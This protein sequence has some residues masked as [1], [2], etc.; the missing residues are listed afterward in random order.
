MQ[1]LVHRLYAQPWLLLTLCA[2]FWGGNAV[3]GRMA[4]G[5]IAPF[6][7]VL[8][9]WV[10]VSIAM[11]ALYGNE[12]RRHW[13]I[14]RP[15]LAWIVI[16][17]TIG[18]TTFNALFYMA[19]LQTTAV[20][21]GILQGTMPVIVL[22]GA[23][24]VYRTKVTPVQGVGVL[25]TLTGVAMIASRG[26]PAGLMA[27][28]INPGDGIMLIACVSYAA[29]TVMLRNRP[30]IPGA[31]FF[32]LLAVVA[33]VT[34]VPLAVAEAQITSPDWPSQKGWLITLFVAIFP[35]CLSQLFFLRGVDLIGPGRAG[36]YF[37][38]VPVFAAFLAVL[39][40]GETFAWYHAVAL[41]LVLGGIALAQRT[42]A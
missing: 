31:V 29:Y 5:E 26:D 17:A 18:F 12:V 19:A 25:I 9:R 23:F 1:H 27:S 10:L 24:L 14:A 22:I 13:H 41:A 21:I 42:S 30:E 35:S 3:A 20:N 15:R 40:L 36:V 6:Q 28:G 7:L 4:V 8:A 39:L 37:N 34:S 33:M 2:L 38:L 32:T 16:L 11:W